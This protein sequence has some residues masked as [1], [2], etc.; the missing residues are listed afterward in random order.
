MEQQSI[1]MKQMTI[2]LRS[3]DIQM[4]ILTCMEMKMETVIQR[5]IKILTLMITLMDTKRVPRRKKTKGTKGKQTTL[6][7]K[8]M[9]LRS[10]KVR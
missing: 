8:C 7:I 9:F 3:T 5:K 2:T 6:A 10:Q 1:K 4:S